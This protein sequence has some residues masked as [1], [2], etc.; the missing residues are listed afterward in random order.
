MK[1]KIIGCG[2]TGIVSAIL[3]KQKGYDVEIFDNRNHIGGN[4]YDEK[5]KDYKHDPLEPKIIEFKFKIED[6]MS[7]ENM[8]KIAK[9][10]LHVGLEIKK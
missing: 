1:A 3:L 7:E 9:E 8:I 2:L 5:I 6:D 10:V 4:C